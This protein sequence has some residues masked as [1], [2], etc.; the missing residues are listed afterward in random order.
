M[1]T[2]REASEAAGER[3][4]WRAPVSRP[5]LELD[6]A[7]ES[8]Q[9]RQGKRF[10][11]ACLQFVVDPLHFPDRI[12][13]VLLPDRFV[14]LRVALCRPCTSSLNPDWFVYL[15]EY[16]DRRG[17]DRFVDLQQHQRNSS[18]TTQL[19]EMV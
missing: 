17:A 15:Q 7:I 16:T 18:C 13:H 14:D 9:R 8:L 12:K 11:S 5:E 19:R 2:A 3:D 6:P 1:A 10:P 4:W